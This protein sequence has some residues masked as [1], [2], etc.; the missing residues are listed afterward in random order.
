M[1]P[2]LWLPHDLIPVRQYLLV[3]VVFMTR[4]YICTTPSTTV[5]T[6]VLDYDGGVLLPGTSVLNSNAG[7]GM[8]S[9]VLHETY[10]YRY[11][12]CIQ[13]TWYYIEIQ[14][15]SKTSSDFPTRQRKTELFEESKA[16]FWRHFFGDHRFH[17]TEHIQRHTQYTPA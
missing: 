17:C 7:I 6:A 12:V 11:T 3:L 16:S 1:V 10:S 15:C 4:T 13:C 9:T 14:R 5:H 2:K 8:Y